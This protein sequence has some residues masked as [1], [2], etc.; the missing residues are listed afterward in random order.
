MRG[1]AVLLILFHTEFGLV[2][3][4]EANDGEEWVRGLSISEAS[5]SGQSLNGRRMEGADATG[6]PGKK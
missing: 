2:S 6:A 1:G 3:G 5:S 4:P